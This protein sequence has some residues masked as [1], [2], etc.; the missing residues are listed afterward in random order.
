[1]TT[2][3]TGRDGWLPSHVVRRLGRSEET[4]V[5]YDLMEPDDFLRQFLGAESSKVGGSHR[6]GP[7]A[8]HPDAARRH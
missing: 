1:V 3:V 7:V 8:G 6:S 2:V 4:V 5:S